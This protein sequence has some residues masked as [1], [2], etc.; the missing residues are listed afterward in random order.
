M[1]RT[2][3]FTETEVFR[4]TSRGTP[5]FPFGAEGNK[6]P[7]LLKRVVQH[8]KWIAHSFSVGVSFF[9][10][11]SKQPRIPLKLSQNPT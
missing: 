11:N 8:C 6:I 2:T 5:L 4:G 10:A 3:K 1:Q 7:Y 9:L